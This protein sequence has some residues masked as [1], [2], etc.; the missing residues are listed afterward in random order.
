MLNFLKVDN[1]NV[2][3]KSINMIMMSFTTQKM[4]FS[5]KGFFQ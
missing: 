1:E 5:I 2:I 4:K 3:A